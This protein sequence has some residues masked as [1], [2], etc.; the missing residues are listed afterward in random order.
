MEPGRRRLSLRQISKRFA[1]TV[2]LHDVSLVVAPGEVH[3][4]LGENGAGKSTLMRIAYGMLPPDAGTIALE[5][6]NGTVTETNAFASPRAAR[7]AGIGMVHQHFTSIPAFTVSDNIAL[8]AGWSETGRAAEGR[9][10]AVVAR[11]G[12][13]LNVAEYVES[14]S[15]QMRQRLEIVKA[16]ATD[17][18]IL[19]LDEPTAVL[20]PRED[21]SSGT[22]VMTGEASMVL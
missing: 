16:L 20:A 6:Q 2:A 4:L 18:G 15:A 13:P 19:L 14:L 8:A 21:C 1:D 5:C 9:A 7:N 11:L 22:A 10:A 17:A 12:L 3:A